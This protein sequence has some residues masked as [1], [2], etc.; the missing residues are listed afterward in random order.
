VGGVETSPGEVAQ[1]FLEFGQ[2]W[3]RGGA[4]GFCGEHPPP[5]PVWVGVRGGESLVEL[6]LEDSGGAA[7]LGW[8]GRSQ[9]VGVD[10]GGGAPHLQVG[11]QLCRHGSIGLGRPGRRFSCG[12]AADL[13]GELS[14]KL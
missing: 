1:P 7:D 3:V 5:L 2:E 4:G 12:V 13:V 8:P 14:N 9:V 11:D 10:L 6:L